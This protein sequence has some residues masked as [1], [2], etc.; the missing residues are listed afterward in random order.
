MTM[1]AIQSQVT[2]GLMH[3]HS[4]HHAPGPDRHDADE[5]V[6]PDLLYVQQAV[7]TASGNHIQPT[8]LDNMVDCGKCGC[9]VPTVATRQATGGGS[10]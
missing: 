1:G 6:L 8:G 2:P 3:M 9:S 5:L 10:D 7:Q 4:G